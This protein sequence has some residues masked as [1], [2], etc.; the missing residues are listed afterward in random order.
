MVD[1]PP[2]ISIG[3]VIDEYRRVRITALRQLNEPRSNYSLSAEIN[4]EESQDSADSNQH[5]VVGM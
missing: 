2:A 4:P 1:R 5:L 3:A